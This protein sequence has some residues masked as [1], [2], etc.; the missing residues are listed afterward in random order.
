MW[1]YHDD[2]CGGGVW[3][4]T[5]KTYKN[6]ITNELFIKAA[7]ELHE[8]LAD[9]REYLRR[10][11][12]TWRWLRRSGT[13]NAHHLVNDGLDTGSCRNN[14]GTVWSYNQG[15]ILGGLVDL[16][17]TTHDRRYLRQAV[18]LADAST[19]ARSLHVNGILREP[20]EP[21]GCDAN[22]PSFKGIYVR[23]LGELA[24]ATRSRGY[25]AYLRRQAESA[26]A[27][28]RTPYD[29]YGIHWRGPTG[30]ITGA[31]QQSAVDLMVAALR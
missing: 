28:A 22:G 12:A 24:R 2:V 1:R 21:A 30:P 6:A 14:H 9:D 27:R 5:R 29:Q 3:W 19:T 23:N 18:V 16:A 26:H 17:R 31:T 13:I 8:R 20:C 4:T 11:K 15:V 25:R 7:A 10:S